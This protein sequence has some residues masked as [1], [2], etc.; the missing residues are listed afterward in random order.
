MYFSLILFCLLNWQFFCFIE[1]Q[2]C[3][4]RSQPK[5]N[6]MTLIVGMFLIFFCAYLNIALF[7]QVSNPGFPSQHWCGGHLRR[8]L[9]HE[10]TSSIGLQTSKNSVKCLRAHRQPRLGTCH[11]PVIEPESRGATAKPHLRHTTNAQLKYFTYNWSTFIC[12]GY[13]FVFET[14][15]NFFSNLNKNVAF[16]TLLYFI[17]SIMK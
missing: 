2:R 17:I 16:F 13:G 1:N 14:I 10:D 5:K 9:L 15:R 3:K 4:T 11:A 12:W 8:Q 6:P 7:L